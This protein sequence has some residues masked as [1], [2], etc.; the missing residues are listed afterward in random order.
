[1]P[2][3]DN[4]ILLVE[5]NPDHA[6]LVQALLEY[7]GYG[8]EIFVT[9][10]LAEAK[11]YLLGEWPFDDPV[12]SPTPSLIILDHWLDDGTGLELLEWLEET[13][14]LPE[15]PVMVFTACRDPEVRKRAMDFG[16]VEYFVKPEGFEAL[17]QAIDAFV[18]P[19]IREMKDER[20]GETGSAQA[21]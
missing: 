11:S 6:V 4:I 8:Q 18:R 5:D 2:R 13:P 3:S 14:S 21:G 15:I 9:Q 1:M 12:R 16:V 7:R 10:S 19:R 17:G 20:D